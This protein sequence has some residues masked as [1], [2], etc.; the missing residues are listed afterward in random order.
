MTRWI[1]I[2]K[3]SREKFCGKLIFNSPHQKSSQKSKTINANA[4]STDE[5]YIKDHHKKNIF[6]GT[7][8]LSRILF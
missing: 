5:I 7:Q 6:I 1:I 3:A 4:T 8:C 2:L